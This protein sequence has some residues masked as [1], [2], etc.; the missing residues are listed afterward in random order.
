VIRTRRRWLAFALRL[1]APLL[2]APLLRA[3]SS[4]APPAA[5]PIAD[6]VTRLATALPRIDSAMLA[7]AERQRVPGIAYGVIVDGRLLHVRAHGLREVPGNAP[8]DTS[9]VFRI[10]SMTKSF[11]ALAILQ[12]RDAGRLALDE[13]AERYIPELA[14]LRYPTRDAPRITVRHLLTHSAGFPEDNPWGDQQLAATDDDLAQML[15]TGVPFSTVPGVQYEYSNLGFALLGRIVQNVAGQPYAQYIRERVLLPLGMTS[16]TMQAAEVPA[17]RLA[18]GY[19]LQDDRWLEEPALPDGAFGAMGGML[20]SAADLSRWVAFLLDAWPARDDDD[21]PVLARASRREMQLVGR[22]RTTVVSRDAAGAL[23]L[24]AGGYGYGLG[25]TQA[26]EYGHLV[27]HSGGLPGFGSLMRWLPEYGVGVIAL[28][29]RT[30]TGWGGVVDEAIGL[31]AATGGLVPREPQPSPVLLALR[32]Q[33]T[34]LVQRWD[35][36]LADRVAAM[37]LFL[38]E[39]AERRAA[40]I[41]RL[42]EAAGGE[43]RA[44]GPFVVENALRGQWTMQC[45]TGRLRVGITL[46]PTE[47]ARV[48]QL[49]VQAMREGETIRRPDICR[50]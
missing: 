31:L 43:C 18:H 12:L 45:A 1:A 14:G 7:F 32:E 35:Q 29:N 6:R 10:A 19:R 26:C 28:G 50:A 8:L 42:R 3:Q 20:T 34:Q 44:D 39:P 9:S 46:A 22:M 5:F 49:T 24:N 23:S 11:T 15:R 16:T 30:Y 17:G 40:A 36:P 48:Q 41:A 13:P 38:D 47:P 21:S 4:L 2:A 27:A 33:V 37:N 25:I